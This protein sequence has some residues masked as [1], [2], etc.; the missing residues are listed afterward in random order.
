MS[1]ILDTSGQ[2]SLAWLSKLHVMASETKEK[3]P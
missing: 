2:M 1:G 3:E